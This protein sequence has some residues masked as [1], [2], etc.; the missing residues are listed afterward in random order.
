MVGARD[1]RVLRYGVGGRLEEGRTD[2]TNVGRLY[3]D[4]SRKRR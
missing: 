4:E 3:V 1:A 2:G